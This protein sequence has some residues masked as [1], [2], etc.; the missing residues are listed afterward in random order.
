M[1]KTGT[2]SVLFLYS[3]ISASLPLINGLKDKGVD[4]RVVSSSAELIQNIVK[5][6]ADVIGISVNHPSSA[7]ILQVIKNNTHIPVILFGED[8][9]T[10]T[11]RKIQTQPADYKIN[12]TIST[13][14]LWMKL[15]GLIKK[16]LEDV[17]QQETQQNEV[18]R[19][20]KEKN[21]GKPIVV[22]GPGEKDK[23]NTG[24]AII[25][26]GKVKKKNKT[27]AIIKMG[28]K[29]EVPKG[30]P[31][32]I[33]NKAKAEPAK[34]P[35]LQFFKKSEKDKSKNSP[36]IFKKDKLVPAQTSA[37]SV[38]VD[39]AQKQ[40]SQGHVQHR[41]M[42]AP[43][44][45]REPVISIEK[46]E[47]VSTSGQVKQSEHKV[48]EQVGTVQTQKFEVPSSLGSVTAANAKE[49]ADN[50][51]IDLT[52]EKEVHTTDTSDKFDENMQP[53]VFSLD[54]NEKERTRKYFK[55]AA[56]NT[57][58]SCFK[59][60]S[61]QEQKEFSVV[62]KIS[63]VPVENKDETGY[64]LF[65]K[66]DGDHLSTDQIYKF[67]ETL[68]N[69][70]STP[71]SKYKIKDVFHIEV[72]EFDLMSWAGGN[73]QFYF[74]FEDADK[75]SPIMMCYLERNPVYPYVRF[76]YETGMYKL[77][78]LELPANTPVSFDAYI[79]FTRNKR[80]ALYL[81][82]GGSFSQ[83]QIQRLLRRGFKTMMIKKEDIP[84]FYE[85]YISRQIHTDIFNSHQKKSE[86]S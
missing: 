43:E 86:A 19:M 56:Y 2:F 74:T 21:K 47:A 77:D 63:V 27:G 45:N 44:Q 58:K 72:S 36:L 12:G 78:L 24:G 50:K 34:V 1:E 31:S 23:K 51:I 60:V 20:L 57:L 25:A 59:N 48:D 81:R 4:G 66:K 71:E 41:E 16:K 38:K 33:I 84:V 85:F 68:E 73:S 3:N 46:V 62:R 82:R 32:L 17:N 26:T 28:P 49:I 11:L 54:P 40:I 76:T 61:D 69:E 13:Y 64:I 39:N 29:K 15:N 80:T 55:Q 5:I 30:S 83:K 70:A 79:Y 7:S 18:E 65:C 67:N 9:K 22:K 37:L 75:D 42:S 8:D 35:A 14:N 6:N 10:E 52:K 53:R